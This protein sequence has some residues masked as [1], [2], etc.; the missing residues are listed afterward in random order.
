MNAETERPEAN[1]AP[2][3][4]LYRC[5][6]CCVWHGYPRAAC[7]N[8]GGS[9]RRTSVSGRG[10]LYSYTVVHRAPTAALRGETPYV[11]AIV[12]TVEGPHIMGRLEGVG[13]VSAR[14]GMAVKI[15]A[16]LYPDRG[17]IAFAAAE[18]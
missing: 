2:P 5:E 17:Y 9:T 6:R 4:E 14:I 12:H 7:P 16:P 8:C 1:V 13:A 18:P 15:A 11:I 3:L 10:T